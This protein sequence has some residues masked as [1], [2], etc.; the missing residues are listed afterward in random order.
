MPMPTPR[1]DVKKFH[2]I[3]ITSSFAQKVVLWGLH[4]FCHW[5]ERRECIAEHSLILG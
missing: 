4:N 5:D 2:W 3:I 1:I